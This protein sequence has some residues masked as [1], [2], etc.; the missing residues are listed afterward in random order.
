MRIVPASVKAPVAIT[1]K[2]SEVVV[3]FMKESVSD[4]G[5]VTLLLRC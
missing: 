2:T 1:P 4:R 3:A 5:G